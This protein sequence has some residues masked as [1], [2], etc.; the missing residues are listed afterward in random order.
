MRQLLKF[1]VVIISAIVLPA[2]VLA[3]S[4]TETYRRDT[5][6]SQNVLDIY[7]F[8]SALNA[9]VI[10]YVHGGA[11]KTGTRTRISNTA[12]A[13]TDLGF[14]VVSVDYRL[15]PDVLVEDQLDDIDHAIRYVYDIIARFGGNPNN[16]HL[17]GHSAGAHLVAMAGVNPG[18]Q[19][20][21][22]V[23]SG[24]IRTVT[25]NDTRAYDIPALAVTSRGDRLPRTMRDV[26][27]DEPTRWQYLSPIYNIDDGRL[28]AFL[29]M[30]SGQGDADSRKAFADNFGAAIARVGSQV[31]LFDGRQ[32]THREINQNLGRPSDVMRAVMNFIDQYK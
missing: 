23:R 27:G 7:S 20:Q 29:I 2:V 15:V 11:W 1:W 19:S 24:A 32:Y 14:V 3:Q 21:Q 18:L 4:A 6:S 31:V 12:R 9:P 17:I 13:Y 26:F 25:A 5:G 10:I 8:D 28:P 22:L 16:I 30:Y